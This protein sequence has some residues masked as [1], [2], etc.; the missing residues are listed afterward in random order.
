[1][2]LKIIISSIFVVIIVLVAFVGYS[3]SEQERQ[4]GDVNLDGSVNAADAADILR[5][6]VKLHSLDEQSL[7]FSDVDQSNSVNAADASAI[8]RYVVKLDTIPPSGGTVTIPTATPIPQNNEL[9]GKIIILDPGHGYDSVTGSLYGG[10]M[11]SDGSVYYAEADKV[12]EFAQAAKELLESHGAT[13]VLTRSDRFMVGNYVRVSSAAKYALNRLNDLDA[14]L[15]NESLSDEALFDIDARM[16]DY[17]YLCGIMDQI[18]AQYT[19]GK[20]EDNGELAQLYYFTP[21]TSEPRVI[22]PDTKRIFEYEKDPRLDNIVYISLHTNAAASSQSGL[23][24]GLLC[25]CVNNEYNP[26]YYNGYQSESSIS[27]ALLLNKNISQQTGLAKKS[28][29]IRIN[30]YFMLRENNLPAVLLEIGYH[31]NANDLAI[32]TDEQTPS[33]V[34]MGIY[35][36]LVEYFG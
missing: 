14:A 26:T 21:Y 25:Y 3:L 19:P 33:N 20:N 5:Y 17:S 31:D 15:L 23:H 34:A 6:I 11:A 30:D 16:S 24:R 7:I 8:L 13:V 12:L 22:H 1:M 4:L 10:R 18:I 9:E 29:T 2:K 28:E 35:L 36:S 27:L 32:I